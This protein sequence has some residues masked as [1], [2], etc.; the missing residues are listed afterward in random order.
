MA[1][2]VRNFTSTHEIV[3]SPTFGKKPLHLLWLAYLSE[4]HSEGNGLILIFQEYFWLGSV[5]PLFS[6][7]FIVVL[8]DGEKMLAI[9]T[10]L[11]CIWKLCCVLPEHRPP[12]LTRV[13]RQQANG[14]VP[15]LLSRFMRTSKC[16]LKTASSQRNDKISTKLLLFLLL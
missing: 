5:Q 13:H 2:G 3:L 10:F 8:R 16:F 6:G 14:W 7:Y 4:S 9:L 1:A 12:F 15:V 11:H